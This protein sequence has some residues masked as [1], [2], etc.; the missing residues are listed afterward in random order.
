VRRGRIETSEVFASRDPFLPVVEPPP[1]DGEGTTT[2]E[3]FAGGESRPLGGHRVR[4]VGVAEGT[5]GA[6]IQV[7]GTL[8]GVS[9]GEDFA[10]SFRLL[11]ISGDCATMLFGD[12]QFTLC[13]GE[14]ILK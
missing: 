8:H 6:Q 9:E 1:G 5:R 7:N 3:G 11:S 13:E 14:E 12:D 2:P 10:A 4:L